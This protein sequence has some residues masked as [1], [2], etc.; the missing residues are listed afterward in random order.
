MIA[1]NS[2]SID[3]SFWLSYLGSEANLQKDFPNQV[4]FSEVHGSEEEYVERVWHWPVQK[5]N[6]KDS[7][8]DL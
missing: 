4:L 1:P 8:I 2:V 5:G 3:S 7:I 6:G